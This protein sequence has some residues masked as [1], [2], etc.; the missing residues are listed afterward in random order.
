MSERTISLRILR[1]VTT[2]SDEHSITWEEPDSACFSEIYLR[3]ADQIY[4]YALARTGSIDVADDVV[5][6]TLLK[7]LEAWNQFDPERGSI[8]AWL[9]TIA[10]HEI[11][12]QHRAH[13]RL[14]RA[15]ARLRMDSPPSLSGDPAADVIHDEMAAH[16][17]GALHRLSRLDRDIILLRYAGELSSPEIGQILDMASGTVRVRMMRALRRLAEDL[18]AIDDVR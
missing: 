13:R 10:K 9:F 3:Y 16:V 4:R 15:L 11:V 5:G 14:L 6:E 1:A 8:A 2:K 7:A 12:N 18:G 17:T